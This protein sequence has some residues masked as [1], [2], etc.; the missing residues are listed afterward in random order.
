[1]ALGNGVAF[2]A[3]GAM[4]GAI[5]WGALNQA[6]GLGLWAIVPIAGG[7]TMIGIMLALWRNA[8]AFAAGGKEH[9]GAP[10]RTSIV[11]EG[12][13]RPGVLS[14]TTPLVEAA[15]SDAAA[16]SARVEG[17]TAYSFSKNV[18]PAGCVEGE[19]EAA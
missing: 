7:A 1:M 5:V 10:K 17:V 3:V 19:C 12:E 8:G 4:S 18:E 15:A 9:A 13:E 11:S 6:A 14:W 2:S 16:A